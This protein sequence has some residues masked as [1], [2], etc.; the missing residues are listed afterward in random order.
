M[1]R[2][3]LTFGVINMSAFFAG[4]GRNASGVVLNELLLDWYLW[5]FMFLISSLAGLRSFFLWVSRYTPRLGGVPDLLGVR[6]LLFA[7]NG[8]CLGLVKRVPN[9]KCVLYWHS[10]CQNLHLFFPSQTLWR[11]FQIM[12]IDE[13]VTATTVNPL[14]V[15]RTTINYI[16]IV[17]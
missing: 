14:F 9:A 12:V 16:L 1:T 11:V 2:L 13:I 8:F 5:S 6:A 7:D 4:L 10:H 17:A 15:H 3:R